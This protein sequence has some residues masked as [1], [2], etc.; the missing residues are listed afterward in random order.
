MIKAAMPEATPKQVEAL[1]LAA[2]TMRGI[3]S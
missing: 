1:T 3:R 2:K